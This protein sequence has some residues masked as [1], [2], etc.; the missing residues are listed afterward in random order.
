MDAELYR[1]AGEI[2][3]A[4][5]ELPTDQQPAFLDRA[6]ADDEALRRE[7]ERWIEHDRR[8]A[9]L[10]DRSPL[11]AVTSDAAPA[12][13][14]FEL[15]T[16]IGRYRLS[17]L[18]G[19]GG[20]GVVFLAT[21]D[22]E[23]FQRQVAIKVVRGHGLAA[24]G[25]VWRF[26]RERQIL[27]ALEH[28]NIAR[29]YDGG[30]T[31]DGQP[32]L[33][34]EYV[35]GLPITNYCDRHRLNLARRLELFIKVC[36]A[37]QYAHRNLVVHRDLKPSNI[38]VDADGEPKL[39]DFGIAKLLD[40]TASGDGLQATDENQRILTLS[41]ASPE[42]I[43]GQ[44]ITTASDVYCLG[45]VLYELLC[46]VSPFADTST[47]YEVLRRVGEEELP[48]PSRR[49]G[50][51]KPSTEGDEA[52]LSQVEIASSRSTSPGALRRSLQGD[53][54]T[55]TG[56]ALRRESELR[57]GTAN[58]LAEDLIRYLQDRPIVAGPPGVGYRLRKLVRRHRAP[59]LVGAS[60]LLLIVVLVSAFIFTL[61]AQVDRTEREKRKAEQLVTFLIETFS[62]SDPD[63]A[64][65]DAVTARELLDSGAQ[66]I[67]HGLQKDPEVQGMMLDAM[68]QIYFQIGLLEPARELLQQ[69]LDLRL[70]RDETPLAEVVESWTHLGAVQAAAGQMEAA[71]SG[72]RRAVE[73]GQNLD[74][75]ELST[76][77]QALESLALLERQLYRYEAADELYRQIL[78]L[79]Q[80]R[81]PADMSGLSQAQSDYAVLLQEQGDLEPS[82][83]LLRQALETR[84]AHFGESHPKVEESRA[85]LARLEYLLGHYDKAEL[86]YR[87]VLDL[88]LEI[89]G[90]GHWSVADTK[91]SLA[92]TLSQQGKK[93]EAAA[94]LRDAI[95]VVRGLPEQDLEVATMISN[96]A[97]LLTELGH[98]EEPE[99]LFLESLAIRRQALG[100][101]H[102]LVG[103][104]YLTL[105]RLYRSQGQLA[106]AQEL[107]EQAADIAQ[108]MPP[109]H[110]AIAYPSLALADLLLERRRGSEAE[111]ILRWALEELRGSHVEGHW[112][113]AMGLASL[114]RSLHLQNRL[115]EAEQPLLQAMEF[116]EVADS[117]DPGRKRQV[118]GW[119]T[120]LYGDM[121]R[122]QQA[123]QYRALLKN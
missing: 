103:Q 61:I 12:V 10:L 5:L 16:R 74:D 3:D 54:D 78:D 98:I 117:N 37:V 32:Y 44:P 108:G 60:S 101:R 114:G 31:D 94:L 91:N 109:G 89:H 96:L 71:E 24:R 83:R 69:G 63:A 15:G 47:P 35:D 27:A 49:V 56:R 58:E 55:I 107:F 93:D 100:E 40:P 1:L 48:K 73:L 30:S 52:E 75:D 67:A 123:S 92:L 119:L 21:R 39:L 28:P 121:G 116:L 26:H 33:V 22:D 29:L 64:V 104:T 87:R 57:Y 38:L 11:R 118:A 66:R 17:G 113:I 106:R 70:A 25:G 99:A 46:G 76:Y 120:D 90:T 72:L 122:P 43:L 59:A 20:M 13:D 42:Q 8:T 79:R 34:M 112:R 86:L 95:D 97:V 88:R 82:R 45:L 102:P 84:R 41:H 110:R 111:V 19:Q 36:T 18:L 51:G 105:G 9:G 80:R 14:G 62:V 4:A 6:C 68:G 50:V 2:F 65:G 85:H 53:L 81:L 77:V 115:Q 7:V 23:E